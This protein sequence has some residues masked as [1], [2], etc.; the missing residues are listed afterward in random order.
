MKKL[1]LIIPCLLS[2]SAHAQL[3]DEITVLGVILPQASVTRASIYMDSLVTYW[4]DFDTNVTVKL[5]NGGSLESIT[6]TTGGTWLSQLA[7]AQDVL[8]GQSQ[9]QNLL[10]VH[11]ADIVLFFTPSISDA[12]GGAPQHNWGE[13]TNPIFQDKFVPDGNGLD[14]RGQDIFYAGVV[15]TELVCFRLELGLHEFGHL[16]GAGHPAGAGHP[17]STF[18]LF[19]D[20]R[21]I[22]EYYLPW[23]NWQT[24]MGV[25]YTA[26]TSMSFSGWTGAAN[27]IRALTKTALSLANYRTGTG[28]APPLLAQCNDGIDN[29]SNGLTDYPNDPGCTS[30]ADDDESGAPPPPPPPPPPCNLSTPFNVTGQQIAACIPQPPWTHHSV[31]WSDVCPGATLFY[32]VWYS[33]PD[34]QPYTFGWSVSPQS[35]NAYVFGTHARVKVRACNAG[36]CSS[37][38]SGSYLALSTC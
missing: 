24:I 27:N 1:L 11:A 32:E 2:A 22:R 36:S 6:S 9:A 14:L 18:Y 16:F 8:E 28:G 5:A 33:Q 4:P 15:S 17:D 31:G 12:C 34:G 7:Q 35:T 19:P 25:S 21:A 30:L 3:E 20:S 37:L 23:V 13:P 29:D 10:N 38:S 26:E